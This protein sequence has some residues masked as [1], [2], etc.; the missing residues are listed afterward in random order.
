MTA[1]TRASQ[2]TLHG[3]SMNTITIIPKVRAILV[4]VAP[5]NYCIKKIVKIAVPRVSANIK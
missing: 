4:R 2:S 5:S 1:Y 3:V